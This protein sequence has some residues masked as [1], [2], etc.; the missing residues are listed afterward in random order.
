MKVILLQLEV[1]EAQLPL[2]LL[3]LPV[4]MLVVHGVL[5][6][7]GALAVPVAVEVQLIMVE[8]VALM[9]VQEEAVL[10]A[11]VLVEAQDKE[12]LLMNLEIAH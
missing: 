6:E 1:L 8:K 3:L 11:T 5:D 12:Q 4:E 9:V 7:K 10:E 2:F